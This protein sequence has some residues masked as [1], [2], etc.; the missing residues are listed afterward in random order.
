MKLQIS[1]VDV[2]VASIKDAPGSLAGKL[3]T[4]AEAGAN[5]EFV[6]ARRAPEKP[7]M[8]VVFVT[9]IKGAAQLRAA[10]KA[11][12]RKTKNLHDIRIVAADRA[13]LGAKLA[14]QIVDAGINL[15]GLSAASIG[16]R[17][18]FNLAFDTTADATRAVR[19]LK[20]LT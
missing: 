12:F 14:G 9:P 8:G 4:L 17:A 1:R 6:I 11:R 5:L 7:G 16:K 19:C 18:I 10:K 20:R 15:R 2:W 13:G 3:E